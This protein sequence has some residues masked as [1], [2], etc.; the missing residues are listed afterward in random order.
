MAPNEESQVQIDNLLCEDI[1]KKEV[2]ADCDVAFD[3][4]Y[5]NPFTLM[6]REKLYIKEPWIKQCEENE[7]SKE[8]ELPREKI[9]LPFSTPFACDIDR[10]N[11]ISYLMI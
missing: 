3:P 5:K 11:A 2:K 8:L 4:L 6:P 10:K 1:E 9:F 7:V